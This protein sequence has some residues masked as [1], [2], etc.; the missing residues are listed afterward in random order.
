MVR[1]PVFLFTSRM[2]V[3]IVETVGIK[4]VLPLCL[5][6]FVTDLAQTLYDDHSGIPLLKN[7]LNI[8][9]DIKLYLAYLMMDFY[10]LTLFDV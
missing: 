1:W 3:F 5:I 8:C 2:L 7:K 4:I 6:P 10:L 9:N